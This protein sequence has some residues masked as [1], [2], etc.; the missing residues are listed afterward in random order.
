MGFDEEWAQLRANA[1]DRMAAAPAAVDT[2]EAG[3]ATATR[4]RA[5]ARL[6]D[7][8]SSISLIPLDE[9]GSLWTAQ[10]GGLDWIC[11]FS[12]EEALA[13]FAEARGEGGQE[14]P[15]LRIAGTGSVNRT[16]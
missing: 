6:A 2:V 13:R 5:V 8:R 11:A 4:E 16:V 15:F 9:R 7:F 12:G 10:L 14:W 3:P 1:V